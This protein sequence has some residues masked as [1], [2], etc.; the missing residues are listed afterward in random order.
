MRK[1]DEVRY[2]GVG[3]ER[4]GKGRYHGILWLCTK[5]PDH[6]VRPNG[7]YWVHRSGTTYTVIPTQKEDFD[8]RD[9]HY[10]MIDENFLYDVLDF[11]DTDKVAYKLSDAIEFM[12]HVDLITVIDK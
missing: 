12:E 10:E 4:F 6:L 3:L 7:V 5:K 11:T 1:F 8:W 2:L 9:D